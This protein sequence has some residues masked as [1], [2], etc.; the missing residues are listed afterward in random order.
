[1]S[2]QGWALL[3]VTLLD[4]YESF[5][6]RLARRLR[7]RELAEDALQETFL[8]FERGGDLG[9]IRSPQAYVFRTALN[10]A[11][12]KRRAD[13]RRLN[14]DEIST[15]IDL[16]DDTPGPAQVAEDRSQV[17]RLFALIE[18]M[19]VRQREIFR[20]AWVHGQNHEAIAKA[21]GVSVRTVQDG[22]KRAVEYC[23]ARLKDET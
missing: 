10:L 4:N 8:R 3:R 16:A 22:L 23:A 2:E 1:M 14:A 9:E 15:L 18:E 13:L 7:S 20:A 11:A 6:A 21:Q 12:N 17:A 19:P 5:A